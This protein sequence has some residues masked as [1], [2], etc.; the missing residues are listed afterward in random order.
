MKYV[1]QDMVFCLKAHFDKGP[2]LPF[3]DPEHP[4]WLMLTSIK[5]VSAWVKCPFHILPARGVSL[6]LQDHWTLFYINYLL[7][8][9]PSPPPQRT[10]IFLLYGH[11]L[12]PSDQNTTQAGVGPWEVAFKKLLHEITT[13]NTQFHSELQRKCHIPSLVKAGRTGDPVEGGPGVD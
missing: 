2:E 12:I 6:V 4:F 9:L 7:I 5:Y 11:P 13:K 3:Q 8:F 1:K 10:E